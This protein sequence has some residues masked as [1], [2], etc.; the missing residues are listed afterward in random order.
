M[1]A[2]SLANLP[3]LNALAGSCYEA[4]CGKCLRSSMPVPGIDAAHAWGELQ[5]IGWTLST[6]T[7]E[8]EPHPLCSS[9]SPRWEEQGGGGAAELPRYVH[10]GV[11]RS[12]EP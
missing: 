11:P 12:M 1:N 8:A 4:S 9:C 10:R 6:S 2:S 5:Q 7:P 3:H